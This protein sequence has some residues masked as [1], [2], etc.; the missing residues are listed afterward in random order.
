MDHLVH[1][2]TLEREGFFNGEH[3]VSIFFDLEKAYDTIWKFF[4][5]FSTFLQDRVTSS[6]DL[7]IVGDLNFHLDKKN[8]TAT[9]KLTE[10]LESSRV[11]QHPTATQGAHFYGMQ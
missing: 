5:E 8:D 10:L 9:R 4:E 11:I 2:K 6:G 3:G 7:L 1:L